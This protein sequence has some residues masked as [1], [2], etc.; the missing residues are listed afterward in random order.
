[1]YRD[2]ATALDEH[3]RAV[4]AILISETL[5]AQCEHAAALFADAAH[6]ASDRWRAVRDAQDDYLDLWRQLDR[7]K[8]LLDRRGANTLGYDELRAQVVP[9][10]AVKHD[11]Q[12]LDLDVLDDARRAIEQLKLAVPGA[13]WKGID[14]RTHALVDQPQLRRRHRLVTSGVV[15]AMATCVAGF[16]Y[17]IQPGTFV[18][19]DAQTRAQMRRDIADI[20]TERKLKIDALGAVLGERCEPSL[21][22]E[23]VK[24]LAMDGRREVAIGFADGYTVRCGEDPVILAWTK[25]RAKPLPSVHADSVS[26]ASARTERRGDVAKAAADVPLRLE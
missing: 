12:T 1:M 15:L 3:D 20:A 10:L 16:F 17:S 23:Y 26:S 22:H 25:V 18:D 14:K 7:A 19:E 2:D 24:Q 5:V 13:D 8:Q 11:A 9:A 21:A 6:A 4:G